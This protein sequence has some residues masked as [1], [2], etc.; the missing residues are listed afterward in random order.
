LVVSVW[1]GTERKNRVYL[2]DLRAKDAKVVAFLDDFDAQYEFLAKKGSQLV[3]KT[4]LDAPRGRVIAID[5]AHPERASWR[6]VVPETKDTLE[7]AIA[8]GGRIL[9]CYLV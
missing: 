7:T 9:C 5:L 8:A 6:T 4:D 3:F 1:Q 2:Q